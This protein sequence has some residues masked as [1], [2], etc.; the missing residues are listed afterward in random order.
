MKTPYK[1][2]KDY[3]KLFILLCEGHQ[4]AGYVDYDAMRDGKDIRRDIVAIK[5]FDPWDIMFSVR[6]C[7]YG[8][9]SKWHGE[10]LEFR[11]QKVATELEAF[12]LAAYSCNLEFIEPESISEGLTNPWPTK[13]IFKKLI[14]AADILLNQR[15]YDGHGWELIKEA[16]DQGMKIINTEKP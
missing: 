12:E 7:Q 15:D 3:H 5:R 8:G 4:L 1:L 16:R 11:G 2:S 14:E 9:I 6:G 10:E 13:D